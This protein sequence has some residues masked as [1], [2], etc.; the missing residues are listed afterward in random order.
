MFWKLLTL[1]VLIGFAWWR[2]QQFL[3]LRRLRAQGL[4]VPKRQG[5]RP[6]SLL[7][8]GL[9]VA[10]GGYLLFFFVSQAYQTLQG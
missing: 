4:P 7:A 2:F 8:L 10:Y 9:I 3:H 5:W 6:I 1:A